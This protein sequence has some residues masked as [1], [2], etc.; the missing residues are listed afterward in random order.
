M[1]KKDKIIAFDF[2]GVFVNNFDFHKRHIEDFLGTTFTN[3]EYYAMHSGNVFKND[4]LQKFDIEGYFNSIKDEFIKESI[5]EGMKNVVIEAKNIGQI[6]IVS[7]GSE[8]N[9][10]E[11]FAE[12]DMCQDECKIYGVETNPS[13]EEKFV[14]I[15]D[16]TGISSENI[17]FITDTLGD[18]LEANAVNIA[19]IA[20]TWGFQRIDT[21]AEG[22]PFGFAHHP[23]DIIGLIEEYF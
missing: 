13:K 22:T 21:L 18:I 9:I 7:S 17:I 1:N 12:N 5:I 3:K 2:D 20:V 15:I 23:R 6:F 14:Q 4:N 19:S 8:N 16:E 11:F 10:R